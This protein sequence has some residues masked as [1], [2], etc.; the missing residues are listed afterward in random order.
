MSGGHCITDNL[1][2]LWFFKSNTYKKKFSKFPVVYTY[3][4]ND[5]PENFFRLLKILHVDFEKFTLIDKPTNFKRIVM[6][7]ESFFLSPSTNKDNDK[8]PLEGSNN[9]FR[10]NNCAFF[11]KEYVEIIEEIR[12]YAKKNYSPL[13][14]KKF[15][16]FHGVKQFG[17]EAV[18]EYFHSKG[19]DIIRPEKLTLEEQ[20][21]ILLNC[22]SFAST[23]GS[24]SHNIIF[25]RDNA[26]VILIPR[27]GS[28]LNIYQ[29][30]LNQIRDLDIHY[31]DSALSIF[32][33]RWDG[34]F[35]Y[36][37]GK[38]LLK[39]FG[40]KLTDDI[41]TQ[42]IDTFMKYS[43]MSRRLNNRNIDPDEAIYLKK[44]LPDFMQSIREKMSSV[45]NT[46]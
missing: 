17:E 23:V 31:I 7:D 35:C 46:R 3:T 9:N 25:L 32:A 29:Q 8:V 37:I 22:E 5:F 38:G 28:H 12:N 33:E 10:G 4:L 14:Q 43:L 6:P 24:I 45:K 19:Y 36:V 18:A 30:A 11:T 34:I 15:Y 1:K 21:N 20:L 40:D 27:R 44:I 41:R 13:S 26:N 2:R 42:N 39:Y 16:F